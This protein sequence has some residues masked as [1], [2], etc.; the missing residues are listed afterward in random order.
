MAERRKNIYKKTLNSLLSKLFQ[1]G[2]VRERNYLSLR[3]HKTLRDCNYFNTGLSKKKKNMK[4][5]VVMI[6][7][8]PDYQRTRRI[9][10]RNLEALSLKPRVLLRIIKNIQL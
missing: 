2:I 5:F 8:T 1:H 3:K 4:F 9:F 7:S 10:T 6:I